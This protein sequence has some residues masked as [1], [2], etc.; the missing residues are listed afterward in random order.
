MQAT[1]FS[2]F[3]HALPQL[4]SR[5]GIRLLEVR[6]ADESLESRLLLPGGP[7]SDLLMNATVAQ[8]TARSL[9]GRRRTV[10]LMLLPL[11]LLALCALA[12]VLAGFDD[13]LNEALDSG[14]ATSLLGA[15]GIAVMMP[16]LGLI[17]GT[18][19]IGPEIDEGSIVYLLA[20]PLNRYSIIVTKLAVAIGVLL[21]FGVI[22]VFVAGL[23][24]TG[25]LGGVTV[26]YAVGAFAAGLAY[27]ALFLCLAVITRNAVVVGLIYALIWETL[28]G[29]LAPGAQTLSRPA[30]GVV[31]RRPDPRRPRRRSS[32]S[33]RPSP[34]P[35]AWCCSL[36]V[37]VGATAYAGRRLQ[38][39]RLNDET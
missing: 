24:L 16:L 7:M 37:T 9:L 35:P 38:T 10:L 29:G 32:A 33:R 11:A 2:A 36:I 25:S 13:G 4:A 14:L 18:G 30:V 3:T 21:A 23:I 22:P 8:L 15:F 6:P 19:S 5:H 28:I 34:S 39:L 12:R 1:D 27:A 31:G 17:A 26:A 20:K